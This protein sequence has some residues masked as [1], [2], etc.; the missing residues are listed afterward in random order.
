M[1]KAAPT[2]DTK[3]A[4]ATVEMTSAARTEAYARL[5]ETMDAASAEAAANGLTDEILEA[6][7]ADES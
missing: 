3:K 6:L 2:N 4:P 1:K 5:I 7:L